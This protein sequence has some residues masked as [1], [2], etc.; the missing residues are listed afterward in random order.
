M[1]RVRR[2]ATLIRR[3]HSRKGRLVRSLVLFGS[4]LLI[5]G[6]AWV[7]A[8]S[9]WLVL[10][11]VTVQGA[12]LVSNEEVETAAQAPLGTPLAR[13]SERAVAERVAV[14]PAVQLVTVTRRWPA[15]LNIRVTERRPVLVFGTAPAAVLVD[16]AGAT[17][18]GT[19]PDRVLEARGPLADP[20]LLIGVATLVQAFPAELRDAAVLVE[21]TSADAITLQLADDREV[22]FGSSEQAGLK[23]EVA[24]AL[25]RGTKAEYI[26]VS[27]PH[28]PSTR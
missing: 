24:L 11:T 6:L 17:F 20:R 14:L 10:R 19:P 21:F 15:T 27:A 2:L 12:A 16:A 9:P 8:F 7:L 26:D 5:A 3:P 28:R 1:S 22:F 18:P 23:A 4:L 25:V 13:V